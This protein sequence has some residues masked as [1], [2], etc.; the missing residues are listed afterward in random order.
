MIGFGFTKKG[1][2]QN[3]SQIAD[4]TV[5]NTI[6]ETSLLNLYNKN[7]IFNIDQFVVANYVK[8]RL[9]GFG[10]RN[11]GTLTI[12][13][14]LGN[15]VI[16]TTGPILTG[17]FNND[18]WVVNTFYTYRAVGSS[19]RV[20]GSGSFLNCNTGITFQ[21][22]MLNDILIDLSTSKIYDITATWSIANAGNS[23]TSTNVFRDI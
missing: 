11:N 10:M 6:T 12:N 17:N 3:F 8:V 13:V 19:G 21:M 20:R 5:S 9:S 16:M 15:I 22:V 1:A 4:K 2:L 23:I 7:N 18:N 14:K